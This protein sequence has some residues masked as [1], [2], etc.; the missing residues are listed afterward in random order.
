MHVGFYRRNWALFV[1]QWLREA[2]L[3]IYHHSGF[4][5]TFTFYISERLHLKEQ[6]FLIWGFAFGEYTCSN[7][8][9]LES[10]CPPCCSLPA[11]PYT[12]LHTETRAH[13]QMVA[14]EV[15]SLSIW[16]CAME[17]EVSAERTVTLYQI[18]RSWIDSNLNKHTAADL[19][20]DVH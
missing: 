16:V 6:L 17:K 18:F 14:F 2:D 4:C 1:K 11:R 7:T 15:L 20:S 13:T 8:P 19:L 9:H 5:S 10:A 12:L 3:Y